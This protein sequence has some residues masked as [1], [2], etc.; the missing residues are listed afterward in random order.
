MIVL[1]L[2][3]ALL[4]VPK[5]ITPGVVRPLTVQ[6]ICHTKWGRDR[7]FVTVAMKKRVFAAYG[8]PWATRGLYEVDHLE[9]R[10][11]GGADVEA[12]L[13]PQLWADAHKKDRIEVRLW[14]AVCGGTI[15]LKDA[16]QDM[17]AWR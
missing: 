16:Q 12:N 4:D 10:S 5:S 15:T 9:P 13:W 6:Q 8:I 2:A 7:R 3:L 14:R 11:L 17:R 1:L